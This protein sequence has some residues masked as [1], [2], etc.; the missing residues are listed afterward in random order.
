[1]YWEIVQLKLDAA[2]DNKL[3]EADARQVSI[4]L[5]KVL[6]G[7]FQYLVNSSAAVTAPA[8][9]ATAHAKV[10]VTLVRWPYT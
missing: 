4:I 2:A 8:A 10:K 9:A 6:P 5:D 7:Y 1:M 3:A